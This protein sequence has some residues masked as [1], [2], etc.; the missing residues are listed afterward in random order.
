MGFLLA[1]N[2]LLA[3]ISL[4]YIA[5]TLCGHIN[6]VES[7]FV[8]KLIRFLFRRNPSQTRQTEMHSMKGSIPLADKQR[9]VKLTTRAILLYRMRGR[10]MEDT[11]ASLEIE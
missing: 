3:A 7:L 5:N 4:F 2:D 11:R 9:V 1:T 8:K 10:D 6:D